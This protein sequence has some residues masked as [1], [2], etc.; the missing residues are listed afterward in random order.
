MYINYICNLNLEMFILN[1]NECKGR[2]IGGVLL[3]S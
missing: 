3:L 2:N 1:F